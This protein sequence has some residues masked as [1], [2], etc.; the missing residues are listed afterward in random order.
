LRNSLLRLILPPRE[1]LLKVIRISRA[2]ESKYNRET[3]DLAPV[4]NW[5]LTQ[6]VLNMD[7]SNATK[8][9]Y[10]HAINLSA[11]SPL[12][13]RAY[14]IYQISLCKPPVAASREKA[15]KQ[16]E[17]AFFMDE[18]I[19]K[20]ETALGFYEYACILRPR[21][22]YAFLNLALVD[23]LVFKNYKRGERVLR[24]ALALSP[25]DARVV[26][27]WNYLTVHFPQG[28]GEAQLLHY[29]PSRVDRASTKA[30]GPQ[31]KK[32]K[33]HGYI[34]TED[35]QWAG[36]VFVDEE[37]NPDISPVKRANKLSKKKKEQIEK[38]RQKK[39]E[40]KMKDQKFSE[41]A[42]VTEALK[43][44]RPLPFLLSAGPRPLTFL[45]FP[46]RFFCVP[47]EL[48]LLVQ[49]CGRRAAG[50]APGLQ[51]L[52]RGPQAAQRVP[53]DQGRPRAVL[54]PAHK[55]ALPV[56]PPH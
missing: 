53:R 26:E 4:I 50:G 37:D 32:R 44:C 38:E 18:R 47:G 2:A 24:R 46:V 36:W 7:E 31:G 45:S 25:F 6:Q 13:R 14:A 29:P 34:V 9:V 10:K 43:V 23:C 21:E 20:F 30:G 12:V 3:R 40:G 15:L 49:P 17:N 42:A 28:D 48:L 52:L 11:F 41:W 8:E 39:M 35:S 55:P 5:A 16:L 51:V 54:R 33:I 22:P 1:K 19:F 56:P 27:C